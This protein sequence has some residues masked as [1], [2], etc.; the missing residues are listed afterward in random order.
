MGGWRW[1]VAGVCRDGRGEG[2]DVELGQR[3]VK[4]GEW[5]YLKRGEGVGGLGLGFVLGLVLFWVFNK[6]KGPFVYLYQREPKL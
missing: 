1:S 2:D 4:V 6:N 3:R 5:Y